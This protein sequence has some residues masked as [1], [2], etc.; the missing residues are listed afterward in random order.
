MSAA[1]LSARAADALFHLRAASRA[2]KPTPT[3]PIAA[4]AAM[5]AQVSTLPI[6]TITGTVKQSAW[7]L[8]L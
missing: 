8:P 1:I 2:I 4:S 6:A 3:L 7:T 5:M